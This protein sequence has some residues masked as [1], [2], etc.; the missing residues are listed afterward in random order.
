MLERRRQRR[1]TADV[2]RRRAAI[3]IAGRV[4]VLRVPAVPLLGGELDHFAGQ[5]V[6]VAL[7]FQTVRRKLHFVHHAAGF[8]IH[9]GG[10]P[11]RLRGVDASMAE[12]RGGCS[13]RTNIAAFAGSTGERQR[14]VLRCI[15]RFSQQQ[16][17]GVDRQPRQ[18]LRPQG[19]ILAHQLEDERRLAARDLIA[20]GQRGHLVVLSKRLGQDGAVDA[21]ARQQLVD[22]SRQPLL[23]LRRL[24][25]I[26]SF[27]GNQDGVGQLADVA[28][29]EQGADQ[30]VDRHVELHPG[31]IHAVQDAG[32]VA[33]LR[34]HAQHALLAVD[35]EQDA[36][37]HVEHD[38]RRPL[39]ARLAAHN[40]QGA[41]GQH[42]ACRHCRHRRDQ[43]P[44]PATA[45]GAGGRR[46]ELIRRLAQPVG[47][48]R[49]GVLHR[50]PYFLFHLFLFHLCLLQCML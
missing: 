34:D 11:L 39:L 8:D 17:E 16:I 9:T 24:L 32:R 33:V 12:R 42:R 20:V 30:G 25:S 13:I 21:K 50:L 10:Q 23:Q 26:G 46:R 18:I 41:D 5:R 31:K 22:L 15:L 27:Y 37:V 19:R 36:R 40:P 29:L 14:G 35:R 1:V 4:A 49:R 43:P 6:D 38:D 2:A 48:V 45:P 44:R 28:V 47:I 7:I 3:C